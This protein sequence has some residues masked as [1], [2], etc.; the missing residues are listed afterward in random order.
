MKATVKKKTY[1]LDGEVIEKV[2]RLFNAKTDTEAIQ[3][4]LQKAIEDREIEESL[5]RLLKEGR[6]RTVYR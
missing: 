2:R 3:R 6:F 5:D 4:A 1:N